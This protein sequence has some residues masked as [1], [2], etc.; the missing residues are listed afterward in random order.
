M[1]PKADGDRS[2]PAGE[3]VPGEEL[4]G[5]HFGRG[6]LL[7]APGGRFRQESGDEP[8][9]Q[10]N[11]GD[12]ER[13]WMWYRP[14]LAP[15]A[16]VPV[17]ADLAPPFPGLFCPSELLSGLTL[18]MPGPVMACG[19]N[20]LVVVATPRADVGH[21][22]RLRLVLFDRLEM[23]VDAEL[24][25]LL[26]REER[27]EGQRLSLTELTFVGARPRRSGQHQVRAAA[28]QPHQPGHRG[29]PAADVRRAGLGKGEDRRRPGGRRSGGSDPVRA[30]PA[31]PPGQPRSG[32]AAG[33]AGRS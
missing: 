7:I 31:R 6:A 3:E 23:I 16:W 13:G 27:F 20:A 2:Q 29:K 19:R 11:G 15:P 18:E 33:R 1:R 8:P 24:G 25:I 4:G 10:V 21:V 5:H 28:G 30:A 32:D 26:R 12:G 17:A 22:P 9:G 14:G